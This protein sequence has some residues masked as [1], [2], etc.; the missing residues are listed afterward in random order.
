M[1][2]AAGVEC[3]SRRRRCDRTEQAPAWR[4]G[5]E[6]SIVVVQQTWVMAE[7]DLRVID[8]PEELR[9]ELWLGATRASFIQ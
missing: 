5:A 3:S 1:P 8:N 9:Y 2:K 7:M 6:G 4:G